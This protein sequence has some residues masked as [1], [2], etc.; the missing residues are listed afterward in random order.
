MA[1]L[2]CYILH[3]AEGYDAVYTEQQQGDYYA[4]EHPLHDRLVLVLHIEQIAH[5]EFWGFA[6]RIHTDDYSYL[7]TKFSY[8]DLQT[9]CKVNKTVES[10]TAASLKTVSDGSYSYSEG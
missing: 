1:Y 10:A 2:L 3:F 5:L 8:S 4:Q 7:L 6:L 9:H